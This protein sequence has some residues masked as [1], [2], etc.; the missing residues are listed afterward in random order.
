MFLLESPLPDPVPT[1]EEQQM[2]PLAQL[3]LVLLQN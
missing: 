2:I 3:F 1:P